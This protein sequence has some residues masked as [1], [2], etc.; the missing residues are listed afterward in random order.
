MVYYLL[1]RRQW[2]IV[3]DIIALLVFVIPECNA[4]R[5]VSAYIYLAELILARLDMGQ[6]SL[7]GIDRLVGIPRF[8]NPP[9]YA[10]MAQQQ[11]ESAENAKGKKKGKK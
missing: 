11:R 5:I 3:A 8:I 6:D 9:A 1:S 2:L 10:H 7:L 4:L